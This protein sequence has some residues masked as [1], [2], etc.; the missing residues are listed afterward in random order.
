MLLEGPDL[1]GI[2]REIES[3]YG[4]DF[5]VIQAE[6]VRSGGIG[7][8]FAKQHYEVTI[9]IVDPRL[10]AGIAAQ[11]VTAGM[12]LS[13]ISTRSQ[14]DQ[15]AASAQEWARDL[16]EQAR[17]LNSENFGDISG[18]GADPVGLDELTDPNASGLG[19]ETSRPSRNRVSGC[20]CVI[21]AP[22][23]NVRS[24]Q[25]GLHR[26]ARNSSRGCVTYLLNHH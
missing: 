25:A 6:Q 12:S 17:A 16:L 14:N 5:K 22:Q 8:F 15:A 9:E 21:S 10:A 26:R 1:R 7:G 24:A 3:N 19:T 23:K 11:P 18:A 20:G 4:R 2:L 13:E